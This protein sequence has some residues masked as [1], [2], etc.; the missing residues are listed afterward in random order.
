MCSGIPILT[1]SCVSYED[2]FSFIQAPSYKEIGEKP[3]ART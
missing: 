2:S 1:W 3:I